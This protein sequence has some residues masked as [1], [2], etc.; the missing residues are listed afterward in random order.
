[1][2]M[3]K[4]SQ[5]SAFIIIGGLLLFIAGTF[6]YLRSNSISNDDF[7]KYS[8]DDLL[9]VEKFVVQ[10]LD[11]ISKEGLL[12]MG[13][14][15]G[16]IDLPTEIYSRPQTYIQTTSG[17]MKLPLWNINGRR[18][19]P[20]FNV[21]EDQLALYVERKILHCVNSLTDIDT[22]SEVS[23][24]NNPKV[25]VSLNAEDVTVV[26]KLRVETVSDEGRA[27][28]EDFGLRIPLRLRDILSSATYILEKNEYEKFL[29]RATINLMS[30]DAD[31][32]PIGDM[33]F[34][35]NR[36]VWSKREMVKT[37]KEYLNF[38]IPRV[39]V[40]GTNHLPFREDISVYRDF[41][42]QWSVERIESEGL[43]PDLPSDI[44]D[45]MQ[46]YWDLNRN[47]NGLNIAF[48]FDERYDMLFDVSPSQGDLIKAS[49]GKSG[50]K[51]LRFLCINIYHYT[52]DISYPIR[53]S[54]FDEDAFEGRGYVFNFAIPVHIEKNIP[55][56][57]PPN[58]FFG[59]A[60]ETDDNFCNL[61]REEPTV[62]VAKDR[63]SNEFLSDVKVKYDCIRYFCDLGETSPDFNLPQLQSKLP[64]GCFNGMFILEKPGYLASRVQD[65]GEFLSI[66]MTPLKEM[67]FALLQKGVLE[68]YS[69]D[70]T[71]TIHISSTEVEFDQYLVYPGD[72]LFSD[73]DETL[74]PTS[75]LHLIDSNVPHTYELNL[76]LMNNGNI[77]GGWIGNW[78]VSP[79]DLNSRILIFYSLE[80][81]DMVSHP[82]P[83]KSYNLLMELEDPNSNYRNVYRPEFR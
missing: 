3:I 73:Y 47:F 72:S 14:Q 37:L 31:N 82:T 15:G 29:G 48:S 10:C 30:L 51:Y 17:G 56:S 39:R 79:S 70:Y 13:N 75:R 49:P 8:F 20:N 60:W 27:F 50:S 66:P 28:Y 1:M 67:S 63:Y 2:V 26:L 78:T 7:L 83:E 65:D 62:I 59:Q 23:I 25:N 80:H 5:I 58:F 77:V 68:P 32:F 57:S 24:N 40:S 44:Y 19:Y 22:I 11:T 53:V 4:K 46:L 9:P 76:F 55:V 18:V 35:C 43:P 81:I 61:T 36:F 16:Y 21:V 6:F 69:S 34:S 71:A 33:R 74:F 45:Y 12:I 41:D 54:I 64:L 42:E 52:Y 38:M